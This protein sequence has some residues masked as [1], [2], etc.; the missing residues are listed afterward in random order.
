[1]CSH[2]TDCDAITVCGYSIIWDRVC[3]LLSLYSQ[4]CRGACR[5]DRVPSPLAA[6]GVWP[7]S[8]CQLGSPSPR[9]HRFVAVRRHLTYCVSSVVL[10]DTHQSPIKNN[11][12]SPPAL[13]PHPLTCTLVTAHAHTYARKHTL[14]FASTRAFAHPHTRTVGHACPKCKQHHICALRHGLTPTLSQ[15]HV[16]YLSV[17]HSICFCLHALP[18]AAYHSADTHT[19]AHTGSLF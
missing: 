14:E 7:A 19:H 1:M 13:P 11:I 17:T 16:R 3:R 12:S 2:V 6:Q 5:E 4:L 15:A 9:P 18:K 8:L 10:T